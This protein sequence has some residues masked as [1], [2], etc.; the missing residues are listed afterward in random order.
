MCSCSVF[1]GWCRSASL[2]QN[3]TAT[4]PSPP[5]PRCL[6]SPSPSLIEC[7]P[8]PPCAANSRP[9]TSRPPPPL[10]PSSLDGVEVLLVIKVAVHLRQ[11]VQLT[12]LRA[13]LLRAR[14]QRHQRQ[15][16]RAAAAVQLP[17][18]A[19]A[20]GMLHNTRRWMQTGL[21]PPHTHQLPYLQLA[22]LLGRQ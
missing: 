6:P 1:T 20:A 11:A 2:I 13:L 22:E 8:S 3:N 10:P 15:Q 14:H 21:E 5:P 17:L 16:Q 9:P 19:A 12:R 18:A 7:C 4:Q